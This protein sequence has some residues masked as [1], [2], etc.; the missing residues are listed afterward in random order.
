VITLIT[1]QPGGGKSALTVDMIREASEK[2]RTVYVDG[3]PELAMAHE[4]LDARRWHEPGAVQDGS[5][6]VIDEAQ[7]LWRPSGSGAKVP[8]DIAELETHRHRGLDFIV[9]TQHP[10]LINANVRRLAGR[11]V[12]LRDLGIL[13]RKWYEWPE[14]ANVEQFRSAPVQ[15]RF[16]LPRHVFAAYKSATLHVKAKRSAPRMLFVAALAVIA[17]AVLVFMAYRSI[18]AKINPAPA[19]AAIPAAKTSAP[20]A[21]PQTAPQAAPGTRVLTVSPPVR[22]REPYAGFG[23]TLAASYELDGKRR[24]W[25]ALSL[26]GQRV[27]LIPDAELFRAGYAWRHLAPCAGVLTFGD[28]ERV[29]RCDVPLQPNKAAPAPAAPASAAI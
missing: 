24:T 8:P 5:L 3:I 28:G 26:D 29:V 22:N 21:R 7:R 18:S 23:V 12:H 19:A 9:V 16:S 11:H 25:F 1:A 17:L 14:A 13:G 20:A 4:V 10:N 27:G 2:G 15:K 6:I